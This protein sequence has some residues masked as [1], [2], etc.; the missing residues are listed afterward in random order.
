MKKP[1]L[2][3]DI[4]GKLVLLGTGTSVGVPAV[5][6]GCRVC[7]E[8]RPRNARTRSSAVFGLPEGNLLIDTSPDLRSQMLREGLGVVHAV[9]YTH[10]HADH[11]AGFDDLRLFQFYLGHPVPVFCNA[12]VRGRLERAFDYAF[13]EVDHTHTGAVPAIDVQLIGDQPF[14][15]LGS[16]VIPVQLEHGP[17]FQ[18]LGFRIG[19]VAYCTDVSSIPEASWPL[20][21]GLDT[22]VLDALRPAAHPTHLN[23]DQAVEI[24]QRLGARQ[25]WFTHCACQLDWYAVNPTLPRGIG[26][27]YDGLEIALS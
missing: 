22:L 17:R 6:C 27:G 26:V 24:A 11:M 8:R 14:E 15:V 12:T 4:R 20:L 9:A 10:E 16:R 19:N 3:R 1:V 18:V 23:I 13:E 7:T 25:T 2:S 5:G 21:E